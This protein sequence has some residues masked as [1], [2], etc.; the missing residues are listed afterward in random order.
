MR[1]INRSAILEIIRRESPISRT[2]ISAK[3]D[4]SVATVMR[5]VDELMEAGLVRPQGSSEWSGGRRRSLLE[6]NSDGYV[7]LGIDMGGPSMYG[8]IADLGGTILQEAN[9]GMQG[10]S[11]EKGYGQLVSMIETLLASPKLQDRHVRGI[12]IGIPGVTLH[13]EGL[14]KWAYAYKWKDLPLKARLSERFNLPITVD[15]DVNLAALGEMWFGVGQNIQDLVLITVDIGIGAGIIIDGALYRG[16]TEASGEIGNMIPNADFLG[17][18]FQSFGALEAVASG[19]AIVER[20]RQVLK[21][22][23]SKTELDR[24]VADDVFDAYRRKEPWASTIIKEMIDYLAV[25]IA[26]IAISFDPEMIILGSGFS[27]SADL[28]V[29]PILDRIKNCI[30]NPPKLVVSKL[31]RRATVMGA[32][33][34]VLHNTSNFYVVHK[35]S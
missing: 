4:I 21:G 9:L 31:G 2:A 8:A 28:L 3:L 24:L 32:I 33:T 26:N 12:G 1:E 29:D 23:K 30:P 35:L 16:A 27:N 17:R 25:A 34:N 14:V 18:D 19:T 11:G 22:K 6:F 5:I 20:A 10:A 15:N 13:I 7:V